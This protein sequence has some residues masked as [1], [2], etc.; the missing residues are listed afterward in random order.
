VKH[1]EDRS[2]PTIG[3]IYHQHVPV[4]CAH[5]SDTNAATDVAY[6]SEDSN[7]VMNDIMFTNVTYITLPSSL[8]IMFRNITDYHI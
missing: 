5:P 2:S 6:K 4:L 3:V 1:E 7:D 8:Q